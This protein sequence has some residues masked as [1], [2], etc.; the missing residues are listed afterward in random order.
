MARIIYKPYLCYLYC[1]YHDSH[2]YG[3][4]WNVNP[5]LSFM[6]WILYKREN[7]RYFAWHFICPV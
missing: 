5:C 6:W 1:C 2:I 4:I 3:K 7:G